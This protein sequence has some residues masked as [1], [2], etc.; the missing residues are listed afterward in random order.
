MSINRRHAL[1]KKAARRLEMIDKLKTDNTRVDCGS[2]RRRCSTKRH[3][4]FDSFLLYDTLG[5]DTPRESMGDGRQRRNQWTPAPALTLLS[6]FVRLAETYYN[7]D[8]VA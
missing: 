5:Y 8:A 3:D 4:S 7:I 1:K 2:G 6:E